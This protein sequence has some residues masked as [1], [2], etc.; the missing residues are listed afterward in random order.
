MH[1][2]YCVLQCLTCLPSLERVGY[3]S[4]CGCAAVLGTLA[5]KEVFRLSTRRRSPALRKLQ[6]IWLAQ[7]QLLYAG[8]AM[9]NSA[10]LTSALCYMQCIRSQ[11]AQGVH[12]AAT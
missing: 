1:Q 7:P 5:C 3:H 2:S 4:D 8:Q 9:T 10:F 6:K 11:R 12:D